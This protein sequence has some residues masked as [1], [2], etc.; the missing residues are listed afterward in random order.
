MQK[1]SIEVWVWILIYG[2]LIGI[3]LG[4][5]LTPGAEL[6]GWALMAAG[7]VSAAIGVGLVFVRSRLGP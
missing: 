2:G 3:S 5:F 1:K 6:A 7:T 4:W